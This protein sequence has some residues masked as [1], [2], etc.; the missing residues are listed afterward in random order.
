MPALQ[1]M[2]HYRAYLTLF[3][4]AAACRRLLLRGLAVPVFPAATTACFPFY[5]GDSHTVPLPFSGVR[6]ITAFYWIYF[7]PAIYL[8]AN[9]AEGTVRNDVPT[10]PPTYGYTPTF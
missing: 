4:D 6:D 9:A 5:R 8:P 10:I 3:R 1:F 7:P 2:H